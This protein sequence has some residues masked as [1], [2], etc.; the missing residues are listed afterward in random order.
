MTLAEL[1]VLPRYRAEEEFLKCCNSVSWARALA[2]RR[3]FA[4]LDR[5]LKASDEIWHRFGP[6]GQDSPG[7]EEE[8]KHT[9]LRLMALI[10]R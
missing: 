5:L 8:N 4:S 1:N 2:R 7:A 3:P 6:A 10:E 9:R